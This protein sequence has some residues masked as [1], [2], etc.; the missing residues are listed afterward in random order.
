MTGKQE[1][2][3]S[4]RC[5][6]LGLKALYKKRNKEKINAYNKKYRKLG[7]TTHG[8]FLIKKHKHLQE[9]KCSKC[10]STENLEVHHIKPRKNGGK[11]EPSN[12]ILLCHKCHYYF[13][14]CLADFW[15][16]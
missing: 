2:W 14:K 11:N 10:A 16:N 4:A 9:K 12:L 6:K 7:I 8:N 5:S 15:N 3:C 1:T 13:E